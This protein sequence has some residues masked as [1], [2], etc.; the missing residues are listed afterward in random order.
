MF[1]SLF[2]LGVLAVVSPS[3]IVAGVVAQDKERRLH[4]RGQVTEDISALLVLEAPV[5]GVK[6]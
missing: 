4:A 2:G 1:G 3:L 6:R 5:H